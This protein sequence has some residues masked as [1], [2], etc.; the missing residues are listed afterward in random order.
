MTEA[1]LPSLLH[2]DPR[3]FRRGT[4]GVW[5]RLIYAIGQT[6]WKTHNDSGRGQF[7]YSEWLGTS[8]SVAISNAY[9]ADR[10]T[11]MDN[12]SQLGLQIGVDNARNILKEFYPDILRRFGHK[13]RQAGT[14]H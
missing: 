1:V 3:Y 8:A 5:S 4:G 2:Q 13:Q 12:V 10:R 7:T 6:S 11:A 14:H 9:Y